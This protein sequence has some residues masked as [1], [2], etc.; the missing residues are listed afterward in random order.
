MGY[1]ILFT[2]LDGTFLN[3]RSEITD[4]NRAAVRKLFAAG[5]QFA[6][7]SGRS[8]RSLD[9]FEK[10]LGLDAPG[11]YGVAFNG[12]VVYETLSKK[13]LLDITMDNETGVYAANTLQKHD[14]DILAYANDSLYA[15]RETENIVKYRDFSRLPVNFIRGFGEIKSGFTK[16]LAIGQNERLKEVVEAVSPLLKGRCDICFS[17]ERLLEF[18]HPESDKG[19]GMMFLA[20]YLGYSRDDIIAVGD[21]NNDLRML[22]EAGLGIAVANAAASALEAADVTLDLTCD[23]SAVGYVID[24]WMLK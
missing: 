11:R 4:A 10:I 12:S 9:Y 18:A 7:C 1:R 13:K 8:W 20:G 2:D 22:A 16:L 23:E 3:S 14:I 6:I 15:V 5:M 17:S 19:S 21:H 24:E